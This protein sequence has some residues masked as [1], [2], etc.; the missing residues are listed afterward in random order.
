MTCA[1][2]TYIGNSLQQHEAGGV[3]PALSIDLYV[4]LMRPRPPPSAP[5]PPLAPPLVAS[6]HLL[7]VSVAYSFVRC[8]AVENYSFLPSFLVESRL[9]RLSSLALRTFGR[10]MT[11]AAD[12]RDDEAKLLLD[13]CHRR[14]HDEKR[15]DVLS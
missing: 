14:P 4:I 13:S 3:P 6:V 15:T 5:P 8:A 12:G 11:D 9:T 1:C 10:E 2:R 7:L